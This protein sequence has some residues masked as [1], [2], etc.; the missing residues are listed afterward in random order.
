MSHSNV[1]ERSH[2]ERE[3]GRERQRGRGSCYMI[4][5]VLHVLVWTRQPP[6]VETA[7]EV[8]LATS[9]LQVKFYANECHKCAKRLIGFYSNLKADK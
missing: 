1:L 8:L 5:S 6:S 2:C 3:G 9:D 4:P 7:L